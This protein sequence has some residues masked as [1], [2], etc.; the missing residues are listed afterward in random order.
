MMPQI[1]NWMLPA[2]HGNS[3]LSAKMSVT[4]ATIVLFYS[5]ILPFWY[6]FPYFLVCSITL[7]GFRHGGFGSRFSEFIFALGCV[8]GVLVSY[9]AYSAA[10][11][12]G[13][14]FQPFKSMQTGMV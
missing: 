9:R 6:G 8:L 1:F 11:P 12:G 3:P 10:H 2:F 13:N 7:L 14:A 4:C 5:L